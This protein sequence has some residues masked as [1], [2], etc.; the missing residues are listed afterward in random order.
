M[1]YLATASAALLA[2]TG[3]AQADL[4][5]ST[6]SMRILFEEV[7]ESGA[8]LELSYGF[9]SPREG[10]EFGPNAGPVAAFNGGGSISGALGDFVIPSFS[11]LY[12]YNDNLSFAL[13]YDQ[14]F[15][16]D[17]VYGADTPFLGGLAQV[18]TGAFTLI[19][20]YELGNGFSGYGGVRA[21]TAAGSIVSAPNTPVFTQLDADGDIGFGYLV[22][23]AFEIPRIALRVA[24]TYNSSIDIDFTGTETD[25]D[26]TGLITGTPGTAL[27]G[28]DETAFEVKFPDNIHLEA[29]TGIAEGTLLFGSVRHVFW[30]GFTLTTP[31]TGQFVNFESDFTTYTIGVGRQFTDNWSGSI[32]YSHQTD[33]NTP[34]DTALSPTTGVDSVTLAAQY[35]EGPFTISGGVT[36]GILGNQVVEN[37]LVGDV[38]FN[39]SD[40]FAAGIRVGVRF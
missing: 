29:Q 40:I 4:S 32:S 17:I 18:E 10:G 3:I 23:G 27:T 26:A 19:G 37:G 12:R 1:K 30:D 7:G 20:R 2:T 9:V 13:I 8:Y 31:T 6:Q 38:E 24:L 22:G 16:A 11:L 21:M 36:Y 28:A 14:P 34:S 15:G 33:G 25:I 35:E 5:R 39:D